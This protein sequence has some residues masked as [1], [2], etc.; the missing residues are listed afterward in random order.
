[1]YNKKK[2][3]QRNQLKINR[4]WKKILK[5][6]RCSTFTLQ[7]PGSPQN[8]HTNHAEKH[9][10]PP[11]MNLTHQIPSTHS[12]HQKPTGMHREP[13]RQTSTPI[14]TSAHPVRI[15]TPT[16]LYWTEICKSSTHTNKYR[17]TQPTSQLPVHTGSTQSL[18]SAEAH[19]SRHKHLTVQSTQPP[20][21]EPGNPKA[22]PE[23]L[24]N[25]SVWP[26]HVK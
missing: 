3:L 26:R 19:P 24:N 10:C 22:N 21:K 11:R 4:K 5:Q 1:M 12:T 15:S 2:V 25:Q 9:P 23:H 16:D 17:G 13:T 8:G 7:P 20:H 18:P 6:L 14:P